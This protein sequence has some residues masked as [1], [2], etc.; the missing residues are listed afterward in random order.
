L[1]TATVSGASGTATFSNAN[2]PPTVTLP[3]NGN[4]NPSNANPQQ[5]G[6]T[7]PTFSIPLNS[8]LPGWV[9]ALEP[10]LLTSLITTLGS[11]LG[12]ILQGASVSVA[13]ADISNLKVDCGAVSLVK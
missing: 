11:S 12:M 8:G 4:G 13:G 7:A 6:W 2:T 10:V 5:I 1:A 9:T 3:Y